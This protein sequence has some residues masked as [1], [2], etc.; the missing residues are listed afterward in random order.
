MGVALIVLAQFEK[1]PGIGRAAVGDGKIP[2]SEDMAPMSRYIRPLLVPRRAQDWAQTSL[3]PAGREA[4][5]EAQTTGL[6]SCTLSRR[7]G[8]CRGVFQ[9]GDLAPSPA[10]F[11]RER[12]VDDSAPD[13]F[14]S[15][16][17]TDEMRGEDARRTAAR[18]AGLSAVHA[19][20]AGRAAADLPGQRLTIPL[21]PDGRSACASFHTAPRPILDPGK[22]PR[23]RRRVRL[24][25]ARR[26][27]GARR[28]SRRSPTRPG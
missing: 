25:F 16:I 9:D 26:T 28:V 5:G 8:F 4:A 24:V 10:G 18:T 17:H 7:D 1:H 15:A 3:H 27:A 21:F 20:A 6:E 23:S 12:A 19:A 11:S 13:T 22:G 14:A 2:E